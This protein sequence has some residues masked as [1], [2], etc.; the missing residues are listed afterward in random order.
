ME[1]YLSLTTAIR[2]SKA[3][4]MPPPGVPFSG[5]LTSSPSKGL[6]LTSWITCLV[7]AVIMFFMTLVKVIQAGWIPTPH[8]GSTFRLTILVVC[9]ITVYVINGPYE[10]IGLEWL[11][12]YSTSGSRLI[13]DL[14]EKARDQSESGSSFA[15]QTMNAHVP[16]SFMING[17][18]TTTGF[19]SATIQGFD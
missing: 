6:T 7:I 8:S 9:T 12:I 17:S 14:R 19:T 18:E 11:A 4:F 5:Y 15:L 2:T 1:L 13:L 10:A 16:I 3:A